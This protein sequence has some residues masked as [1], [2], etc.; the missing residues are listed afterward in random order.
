MS[1]FK[2]TAQQAIT[3]LTYMVVEKSSED[4]VLDSM[5]LTL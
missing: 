2:P 5:G 1:K 4:T 3:E